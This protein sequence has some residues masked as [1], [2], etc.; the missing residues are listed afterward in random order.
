MR[1]VK[2][3]PIYV[4]GIVQGVGFRS[5][6]YK[7]AHEHSLRGYVKFDTCDY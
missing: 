4:E 3:Y 5:L 6:I 7:I 1:V 2:T